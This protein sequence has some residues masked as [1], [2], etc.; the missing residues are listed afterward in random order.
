MVWRV[1]PQLGYGFIVLQSCFSPVTRY[2]PS[3]LVSQDTAS[4][5]QHL[6][7]YLLCRLVLPLSDFIAYVQDVME[8]K[9]KEKQTKKNIWAVSYFRHFYFSRVA[10]WGY[11]HVRGCPD[12]TLRRKQ[13]VTQPYN[14]TISSLC[15]WAPPSL[16]IKDSR[17]LRT[18]AINLEKINGGVVL[19]CVPS[20]HWVF[21]LTFSCSSSVAPTIIW[22]R[23]WLA[24]LTGYTWW[25]LEAR[26]QNKLVQS[27]LWTGSCVTH[28]GLVCGVWQRAMGMPGVGIVFLIGGWFVF[29]V[30]A[31]YMLFFK[32]RMWSTEMYVY[33]MCI[34]GQG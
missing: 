32:G 26:I 21:L 34:Y 13:Q 6:N 14:H 29:L 7:V 9:K 1:P 22:A 31:M 23:Q 8:K 19:S 12:L 28:V 27:S 20:A 2:F 11:K 30:D 25:C 16:L 4:S 33:F 5:Q 10:M 17:P 3:P 15:M 18:V 24:M